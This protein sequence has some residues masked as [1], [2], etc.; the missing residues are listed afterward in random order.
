MDLERRGANRSHA[1]LTAIFKHLETGKVLRALTTD[2]SLKGMRMTTEGT[3]AVGMRLEIELK[4]P[5]R[6]APIVCQAEV[7][8]SRST[9]EAHKSYEV[10]PAETGVKFLELTPQDQAAIRHYT[11]FS[12][13]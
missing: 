1:R 7:I 12:G 13:L 5:D 8:W 3:L 2:L 11:A 4:L 6:V 9:N 10:P